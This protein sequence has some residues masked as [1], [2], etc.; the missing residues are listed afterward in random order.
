MDDLHF[1][2]TCFP[3]FAKGI[4]KGLLGLLVKPIIGISD[5][6][7]DV[8]IGVKGSVEGSSGSRGSGPVQQIRPRRALYGPDRIVRSYN[9]TDAAACALMMRSRLA[10]ENY[11]SHLDMGDRVAL[12][13][14]KRLLLLG[15]KGEEQ[16]VLKFKHIES[17]SVREIKQEDGSMG[18]GIIVVLNTPRRN[19]SEVEVVNCSD[20]AQAEELSQ[21]LDQGIKLVANQ[22]LR[23]RL[24][25]GA[26]RTVI[27]GTSKS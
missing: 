8:M 22:Q 20:N 7:T 25:I 26:D 21:L 24:A 5:G 9:V 11:L 2:T 6:I 10:G 15:S 19:G 27:T 14:A 18:W 3:G 13:S 17:L 1:L 16:L 4:G 12:L 23:D